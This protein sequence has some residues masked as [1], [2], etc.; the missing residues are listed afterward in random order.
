MWL[1]FRTL[2]C[3][4]SKTTP[5]RSQNEWGRSQITYGP[6]SGIWKANISF[7]GTS[8]KGQ[9]EDLASGHT[10]RDHIQTPLSLHSFHLVIFVHKPSGNYGQARGIRRHM[11]SCPRPAVSCLA[12]ATTHSWS[13]C[14]LVV[15]VL[16][17]NFL[18]WSAQEAGV[19]EWSVCGG[20]LLVHCAPGQSRELMLHRT[21]LDM[22][23]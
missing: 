15:V 1:E 18:F 22:L 13:A 19:T 12:S 16:S 21:W 14:L 20:W 3:V 9:S 2:R 6:F 11:L 17:Q 10:K 8:S 4:L 5:F 23:K 7:W